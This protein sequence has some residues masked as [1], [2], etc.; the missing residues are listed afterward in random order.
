MKNFEYVNNPDVNHLEFP[1]AKSRPKGRLS[2]LDLIAGISF[3]R[4]TQPPS[5]V[6]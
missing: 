5:L 2:N 3:W 4:S 6:P 1:T